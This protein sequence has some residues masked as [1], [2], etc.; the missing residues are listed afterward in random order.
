MKIAI[1]LT[2]HNR[3]DLTLQCLHNLYNQKLSGNTSFDIYLVDDGCTDGTSDAVHDKYPKTNIIRGDGTLFWN[4]GMYLAWDTASKQHK[5]DAFLWIND[6]T[7]LYEDCIK[8]LIES[9]TNH[10]NQSIIVGGC[11]W[12]NDVERLSYGGYV[13]NQRL[14]DA[15]IEYKCNTMN[16]NIVFVPNSVYDKIGNL[17]HTFHHACGDIDYGY[18][19]TRKGIEIYQIKGFCGKCN[20]HE[21]VDKCFDL[22]LT[23]SQRI[24]L[25]NRNHRFEDILI[26]DIR[27]RGLFHA[28]FKAC[29]AIVH[30][31]LP[32][33]YDKILGIRN[34]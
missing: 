25:F 20:R 16:G 31:L 12:E 26:A 28:T 8:R 34:V 9:S 23:L 2:C 22:N 32:K 19:A 13:D 3:K 11:C 29:T 18:R 27:H 10:N 21:K 15:S 5:Y 33:L 1:L 17:D 30:L 24:K 4:R 14:K 7:I 6:D